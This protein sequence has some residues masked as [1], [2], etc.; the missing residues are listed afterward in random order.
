MISSFALEK[1]SVMISRCDKVYK[2][3]KMLRLHQLSLDR[4]DIPTAVPPGE[5]SVWP[6]AG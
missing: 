2:G 4:V 5:V 1:Q 6:T 3:H